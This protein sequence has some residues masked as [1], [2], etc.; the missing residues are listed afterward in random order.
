MP[1]ATFYFPVNQFLKVSFH[2]HAGYSEVSHT[3]AAWY[4]PLVGLDH[5]KGAYETSL[6]LKSKTALPFKVKKL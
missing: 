1:Q 5:F 3:K 4:H 6:V 2:S